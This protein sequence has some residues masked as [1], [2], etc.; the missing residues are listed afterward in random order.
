MVDA[1]TIIMFIYQYQREQMCSAGLL[2]NYIFS[3]HLQQLLV[4]SLGLV[5]WLEGSEPILLL[6]SL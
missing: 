1:M 4:V 3:N 2:C 6:L 5:V